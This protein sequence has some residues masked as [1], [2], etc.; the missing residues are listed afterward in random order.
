MASGALPFS[1]AAWAFLFGILQFPV[2]VV[3]PDLERLAGVSAGGAL[4]SLLY[5][6]AA[7][8]ASVRV[9]LATKGN[10]GVGGAEVATESGRSAAS[11]S[12]S[13]AWQVLDACSTILFA[14]G[15]HFVSFLF[16]FL[17]FGRGKRGGEEEDKKKKR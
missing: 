6:S 11:S 5:A 7:V 17:F 13:S 10:G 16:L 12:S 15:G 4:A 3:A 2:A 8:V 9:L 14:F 1:P